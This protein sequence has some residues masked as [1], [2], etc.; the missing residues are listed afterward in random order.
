MSDRAHEI[1]ARDQLDYFLDSAHDHSMS[2]NTLMDQKANILM[3]TNFVILTILSGQINTNRPEWGLFTA[4]F[5]SLGSGL[6][7]LFAV[8][9]R[10]LPKS[11][12]TAAKAISRDPL[13]SQAGRHIMFFGDIAKMSSAEYQKEMLSIM[14]SETK[15]YT[16][17]LENIYQLSCYVNMKFKLC[18][19]SY[20]L[21]FVGISLS[22]GII[23]FH[24]ILL[25]A[26]H[27]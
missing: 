16:T 13:E 17:R 26:A 5:F 22:I 3:A 7:A 23:F 19:I 9:P 6:F 14:E 24:H 11:I 20:L 8:M 15:V 27:R 21:L 4:I 1:H 2:L 12:G 25:G 18:R 10:T